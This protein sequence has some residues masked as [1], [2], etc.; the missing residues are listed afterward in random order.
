MPLGGG[1]TSV[2]A[3]ETFGLGKCLNPWVNA[4][5]LQAQSKALLCDHE[6]ALLY[7]HKFTWTDSPICITSSI[8]VEIWTLSLFVFRLCVGR[9]AFS[10]TMSR[11][12]FSLGA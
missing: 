6:L 3:L 12:T 10:A 7:D 9:G 5:K 11:H 8:A 4:E 2:A 1:N